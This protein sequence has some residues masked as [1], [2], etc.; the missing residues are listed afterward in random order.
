LFF[1]GKTIFKHALLIFA[2][3]KINST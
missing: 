1:L 3:Y 2:K